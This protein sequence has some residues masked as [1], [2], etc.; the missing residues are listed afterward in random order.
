MLACDA[1]EF[2][3][4]STQRFEV[5]RQELE[6]FEYQLD[7]SSVKYAVPQN[8]HDDSTISLALAVHAYRLER[9][10]VWGYVMLL[11]QKAKDIV[12]GTRDMFGE[13]IHKPKKPVPVVAQKPIEIRTEQPKPQA[14][15]PCPAPGCGSISTILIS[16]GI[17]K[18]VLHCNQ[19]KADSLD[20][21]VLQAPVGAD[22]CPN[23]PDGKH[24]MVMTGGAERCSGCQWTPD[25][26][27]VQAFNGATFG[28]LNAR[29]DSFGRGRFGRF[30]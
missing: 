6:S 26:R 15:Q 13:L 8:S 24:R 11:Q 10:A 23:Y 18:L 14:K 19:C 7:G 27:P 28:E 12:A 30:S 3:V 29:H 4:P 25:A 1:K 16:A 20:G 5:Y 17:G 9:G 2:R 21:V 22:R